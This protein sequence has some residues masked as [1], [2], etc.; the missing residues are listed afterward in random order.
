MYPEI[1]HVQGQ[2]GSGT[3]VRPCRTGA[4]YAFFA[5]VLSGL[6]IG[7]VSAVVLLFRSVTGTA[8]IAAVTMFAYNLTQVPIVGALTYSQGLVPLVIPFAVLA[9]VQWLGPVRRTL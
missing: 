6:M 9:I 7:A 8:M 5:M 4:R 3:C 1:D 2:A